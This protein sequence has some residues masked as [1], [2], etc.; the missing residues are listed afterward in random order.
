MTRVLRAHD[1]DL[2]EGADAHE[3]SSASA[4]TLGRLTAGWTTP[5]GA[6]HRGPFATLHAIGRPPHTTA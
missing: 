3:A 4:G 6:G 1:E 5:D 2:R